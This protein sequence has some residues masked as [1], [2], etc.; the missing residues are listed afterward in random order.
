MAKEQAHSNEYIAQAV[1]QA[2]RVAI[3]TMSI[4]SAART[5][6]MDPE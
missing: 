2:A 6:N 1:A 4:I 3:Q 5:E